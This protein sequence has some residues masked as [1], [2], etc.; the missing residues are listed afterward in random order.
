M[1]LRRAPAIGRLVEDSNELREIVINFGASVYLAHY[2]FEPALDAWI[3]RAPKDVMVI[4]SKQP[5][6]PRNTQNTRKKARVFF[7]GVFRVF[8]G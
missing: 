3:K 2:R 7:F 8:R 4:T 1:P 6:K 5:H